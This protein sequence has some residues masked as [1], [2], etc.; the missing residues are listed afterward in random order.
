MQIQGS[1]I[2]W[3]WWILGKE[4]ALKLGSPGLLHPAASEAKRRQSCFWAMRCSSSSSL[5][6]NLLFGVSISIYIWPARTKALGKSASG[7]SAEDVSVARSSAAGFRVSYTWSSRKDLNRDI[8][9]NLA[10]IHLVHG[11]YVSTRNLNSSRPIRSIAGTS[12]S[13]RSITW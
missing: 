1:F 2:T 10:T 12:S 5:L 7:F 4:R 8:L 6:L 11:N 3:G 9:S 13:L